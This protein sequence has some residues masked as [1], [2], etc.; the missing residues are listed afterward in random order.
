M[1]RIHFASLFR[2]AVSAILVFLLS[3]TAVEFILYKLTGNSFLLNFEKMLNIS[4]S[5]R[6]HLL[7]LTL[8]SMEMTGVMFFYAVLR[9]IFLSG[10][11]PLLI[12]IAF[13]LIFSG[14]FL[15]QM[16]NLGIYPLLAAL[17]FAISSLIG[18]PLAVL[19]GA[20]VYEYRTNSHN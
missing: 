16:I 8:F 6:F 1:L 12:S 15:G 3:D 7:N 13:F 2:A 14:L 10:K 18:F 4:Y 5:I 17:P 9:S 20:M 11:K 19:A